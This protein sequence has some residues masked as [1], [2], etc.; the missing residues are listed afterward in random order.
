MKFKERIKAVALR[1]KGRSYS[2]IIKKI[3]VSKGTLS[4]WLKDVELTYKQKERL[5]IT[6]KQKNAL[7]ASD[8]PITSNATMLA[9]C[10]PSITKPQSAREEFGAPPIAC[11]RFSKIRATKTKV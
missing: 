11:A 4:V 5:Y 1:K 9:L 7:V 10:R 8:T 2:E 3:K 6:L